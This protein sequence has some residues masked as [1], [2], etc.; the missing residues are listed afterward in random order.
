MSL[1]NRCIPVFVALL[2]LCSQCICP[3]RGA[4][5]Q[6]DDDMKNTVSPTEIGSRNDISIFLKDF[7][8][9]VTSEDLINLQ[10]DAN[11]GDAHAHFVLGALQL[12]GYEEA[13]R[14]AIPYN[15]VLA[16]IHLEAAARKHHPLAIFV[17]AYQHHAGIHCA[18][19]QSKA[20]ELYRYLADQALPFVQPLGHEGNRGHDPDL[21]HLKMVQNVHR[22]RDV[23]YVWEYAATRGS[24][25]PSKY[26]LAELHETGLRDIPQDLPQALT[27]YRQIVDEYLPSSMKVSKETA[28]TVQSRRFR[29]YDD[30]QRMYVG[31]TAFRLG[32][33]A[34]IGLD[35]GDPDYELAWAWF[36]KGK[37]LKNYECISGLAYMLLHGLGVTKNEALAR[38]YLESAEKAVLRYLQA[39]E[40][41]TVGHVEAVKRLGAISAYRE[42]GKFE[43]ANGKREMALSHLQS[44]YNAHDIEA[45]YYLAHL[46]EQS[47]ISVSVRLYKEFAEIMFHLF[48]F[49]SDTLS[50]RFAAEM[51]NRNAQ[52]QVAQKYDPDVSL[53]RTLPEL[54][55]ENAVAN[56]ARLKTALLFYS[57]AAGQY[58]RDS[59][60]KVGDFYRQGLGTQVDAQTAMT[61]YEAALQLGE[62]AFVHWRLGWMHEKG[63]G[64]PKDF[65]LAKRHYDL[66]LKSD[67]RA[68]L[69]ST[70]SLL[71]LSILKSSYA[72]SY[73]MVCRLLN[74]AFRRVQER[75]QA[76]LCNIKLLPA[77]VCFLPSS[78]RASSSN[79]S[80]ESVTTA[81]VSTSSPTFTTTEKKQDMKEDDIMYNGFDYVDRRLV[82]TIVVTIIVLIVGGFFTRQHLR[83]RQRLREDR[84]ARRARRNQV[85]A[86]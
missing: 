64:V 30:E 69:M 62:S 25:L 56:D 29:D 38:E 79:S 74:N 14:T 55:D 67:K 7:A 21:Y 5:A 40:T 54:Y 48:D 72:E 78:V 49:N 80:Q 27:I 50:S 71:R 68:E 32:R 59:I 42:L 36:T 61:Y 44:V 2:L 73:E 53:L 12:F 33:L 81:G 4:R 24:D 66:M 1:L 65:E 31:S 77:K 6:N 76:P 75:I 84:L 58:H 70:W 13:F 3:V 85:A 11:S 17:L 63:L 83:N 16:R 37:Q 9:T 51:G 43:Y 22:L 34:L 26:S 23:V 47:D 19:N 46:F 52:V 28:Q 15:P 35:G 57:R 20:L 18:Q 82:E 39:K 8:A 60:V 41:F 10:N 45:G 86:H